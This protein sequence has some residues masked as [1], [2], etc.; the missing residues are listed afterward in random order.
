MARALAQLHAVGGGLNTKRRRGAGNVHVKTETCDAQGFLDFDGDGRIGALQVG[1]G[2]DHTVDVRCGLAGALQGLFGRTD[3]HL[4]QHR[5]FVVRT[6]RQ[7]W[8]HALRVEDALLV[9]DKAA[10]DPGRLFDEG[11]AGLGQR[12]HVAALDS[13][14]VVGIEL[15]DV[16]I[17][18]LHQLFVGDAVGRGVQ[19]GAADDD[20]MH[21]R[22]SN[23]FR[24]KALAP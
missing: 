23:L 7:A 21:G 22:F 16:S 6:L 4:A 10:F 17:E 3:G 24:Q 1:A 8:R 13:V 19:A 14:G 20:V 12:L 5:P 18:R 15:A 2:D 11:C 9:H